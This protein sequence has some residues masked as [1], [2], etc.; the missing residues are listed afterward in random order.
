[1]S[2]RHD[3]RVV[4]AV[5]LNDLRISLT[6]RTYILLSVAL[7]INFLFLF[8][9]FVLTG[10]LAPTAVV[11][12]D[13]GPFAQQF[14]AALENAHS[15]D[16][17]QTTA[18][19]ARDLLA[20]GRIV[21]IVTVPASFDADLRAGRRVELPVVVN[22][23]QQDFTNDI[24]RAVPLAITSFYAQAF[25]DQVVV[26]A[27]EV[28]LQPQDTG[29]IQYLSVSILVI[30]LMVGG[31][32]QAGSN[33]A[34]EHERETIKELLLSP[35]KRWAIQAGKALGAATLNVLSAAVTLAVV[36]LV[37]GVSPVHWA[38]T[39]GFA[40]LLIAIFVS[41]GSLLGVLVRRRQ[42][43]IPLVFGL[44]L[45]L[46]FISGAFGPVNWGAPIATAIAYVSPAY[47]AIGVLQHA[48]H[49]FQ[50]TQTSPAL[51]A[52]ILA[53]AAVASIAASA[54]VLRRTLV[55]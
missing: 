39:V 4:R 43:L 5:A 28:D 11:L 9:L 21:A 22:N 23:L 36:V 10:G 24:R 45:P 27:R 3:L 8:L 54:L 42:S 6:E 17:R 30:G 29:Y 33:V 46:F 26:Q 20:Q 31:L 1:M 52:A 51:D 41:L 49:G 35:A 32:L 44:S 19:E 55:H 18:A 48:F 47:Y 13:R 38:E 40:L 16:V 37:V 7:P 15:F 34:R 2:L 25:P 12:E 53:V 50:T 14:L